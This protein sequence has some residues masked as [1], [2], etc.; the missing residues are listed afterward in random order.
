MARRDEIR[1]IQYYT[2][3]SAALQPERKPKIRKAEPK[4]IELAPAKQI[5]IRFDPV[6]VMG[7]VVAIIMFICM[8]VGFS[9]VNQVN[10]QIAQAETQISG[11]KAE[12]SVLEAKYAMGY[13]L[14]EIRIAAEAMGMVSADQVQ[15]VTLSVSVPQPEPEPTWWEQI[16]LD[17]Q[18]LFA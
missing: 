6:A 8:M 16:L 15:H 13:D 2:P 10:E 3:G 1:Y 17:I 14:E 4:V 5:A 7:T 11:L 12:Y 18:E 9:Q